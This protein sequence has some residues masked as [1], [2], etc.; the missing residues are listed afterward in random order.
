MEMEKVWREIDEWRYSL[1]LLQREMSPGDDERIAESMYRY[2]FPSRCKSLAKYLNVSLQ[3]HFQGSFAK[4]FHES[5][6]SLAT[7]YSIY[8]PYAQLNTHRRKI[9]GRVLIVDDAIPNL[10]I[11]KDIEIDSSLRTFTLAHEIVHLMMHLQIPEKYRKKSQLILGK[12]DAFEE[13]LTTSHFLFSTKEPDFSHINEMI[14]QLENQ[15]VLET[16]FNFME[17]RDQ[18]LSKASCFDIYRYYKEV[19]ADLVAAYLPVSNFDLL[20][21]KLPQK[22]K[23]AFMPV[24]ND[25]DYLTDILDLIA[26]FFAS[27]DFSEEDNPQEIYRFLTMLLRIAYDTTWFLPKYIFLSL[28]NLV[29]FYAKTRVFHVTDDQTTHRLVESFYISIG[30]PVSYI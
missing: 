21:E 8:E 9:L 3:E 12:N 14:T 29:N 23:M 22:L 1:S 13:P 20:Y 6:E 15:D 19:A 2:F 25:P 28:A 10:Q 27:D 24:K 30:I 18:I 11:N 5:L 16:A 26:C 4:S 17:N 7:T